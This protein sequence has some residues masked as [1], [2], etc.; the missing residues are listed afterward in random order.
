MQLAALR[1]FTTPRQMDI[2]LTTWP[3]P[4]KS[5][6]ASFASELPAMLTASGATGLEV[7][8]EGNWL[9][10]KLDGY[11]SMSD[12]AKALLDTLRSLAQPN[13]ARLELTT[14]PF[15]PENGNEAL[16]APHMDRLFPQAYSVANRRNGPIAW[17]DPEGPGRLQDSSAKR[18][19]TIAGVSAGRPGLA[20]GLPAYDQTFAGHT[21][22]EAMQVALDAAIALQ[23]S[24]VRYWSSKWVIGPMRGEGP[25]AKFL[26]DR[27][28]KTAEMPNLDGMRAPQNDMSF[29][30]TFADDDEMM[31]TELEDM[32]A[33]MTRNGAM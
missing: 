3:R 26:L 4:S 23:V 25:V 32:R 1:S 27:T 5:L 2:V 8:T 15:H 9:D 22:A 17:T 20:M 21:V 19:R 29:A 28:G 14:Y 13:K 24:E 31:T 6:I 16:V 18:A 10:S 12:A 7:D 30:P 11:A 33:E